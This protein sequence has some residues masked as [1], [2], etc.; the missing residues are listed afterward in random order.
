MHPDSKMSEQSFHKIHQSHLKRKS[1]DGIV[2]GL[3]VPSK[4]VKF[5][6]YQPPSS[7]AALNY[8]DL[9]KLAS[10]QLHTEKQGSTLSQITQIN[11]NKKVSSVKNSSESKRT[12]QSEKVVPS[13]SKPT[14]E[15]RVPQKD[16]IST[17]IAAKNMN[18][19]VKPQIPKPTTSQKNNIG[20]LKSSRNDI[21]RSKD[22]KNVSL[23]DFKTDS[24]PSKQG[25]EGAK[26]N[27]KEAAAQKRSN[28]QQLP[29]LLQPSKKSSSPAISL[30]QREKKNDQSLNHLNNKPLSHERKNQVSIK[31]SEKH[32]EKKQSKP[33][34]ISASSKN[35]SFSYNDLL[36]IASEQNA[37]KQSANGTKTEV[38]YDNVTKEIAN[39]SKHDIMDSQLELK[40]NVPP[41]KQ[42][43]AKSLEMLEKAKRQMQRMRSESEKRVGNIPQKLNLVPKNGI[44]SKASSDQVSSKLENKLKPVAQQMAPVKEPP[45]KVVDKGQ[46][47]KKNDN[48]SPKQ[49]KEKLHSG[50]VSV[51]SS[52]LDKKYDSVSER[53]VQCQPQTKL[54]GIKAQAAE[55]KLSA[56]DEI[57]KR[58]AIFEKPG[59]I[60]KINSESY[61]TVRCVV[62][63]TVGCVVFITV[64]CVVFIT[65]QYVVF[66]RV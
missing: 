64:R 27:M 50:Q 47:G 8:N 9:L 45:I 7:S 11:N 42:L 17:N 25:T 58:F 26:I 21:K 12:S 18:D 43:S 46:Q 49:T 2:E 38:K 35:V 56:W 14:T 24:H 62:L 51:K 34:S 36:K 23:K 4:K 13:V 6:S 39:P 32:D 61:K 20:V 66:I 29:K 3:S 63:I 48:I 37:G 54:T 40:N 10:Q 44:I 16:K 19:I 52:E 53:V 30:I 60:E 59:I 15:Q 22:E 28:V 5:S 31:S 33:T 1:N 55:N 41:V 65:V 57:G